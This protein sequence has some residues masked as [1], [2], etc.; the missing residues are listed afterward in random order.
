M[1]VSPLGGGCCV[2]AGALWRLRCVLVGGIEG[3]GAS[4]P[5]V[6]IGRL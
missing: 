4:P 2:F 1:S 3:A 6:K 5:G